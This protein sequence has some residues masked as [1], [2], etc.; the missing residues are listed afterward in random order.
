LSF[1]LLYLK[2]DILDIIWFITNF[3]DP[4]IIVPFI[5]CLMGVRIKKRL[6]LMLPAVVLMAEII[7]SRITGQFDARS[8]T[9]GVIVPV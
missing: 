9:V 2:K 8:F 4:L 7:T 1:G 3:W 5:G 6:F